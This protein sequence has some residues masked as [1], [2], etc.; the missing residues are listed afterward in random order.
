[1][2]NLLTNLASAFVPLACTGLS[3]LARYPPTIWPGYTRMDPGRTYGVF[4][5]SLGFGVILAI[6]GIWVA[7]PRGRW[8]VG[9]R[10]CGHPRSRRDL[11]KHKYICSNGTKKGTRKGT[12]LHY[13][14]VMFMSSI[15]RQ[16][17]PNPTAASLLSVI[18]TSWHLKHRPSDPPASFDRMQSIV[19]MRLIGWSPPHDQGVLLRNS[20]SCQNCTE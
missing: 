5:Q 19:F 9:K 3:S 10:T 4:F 17:P 18:S 2:V 7:G 20:V 6:F 8:T 15:S 11:G 13:S 1:V 14:A 16:R 12:F